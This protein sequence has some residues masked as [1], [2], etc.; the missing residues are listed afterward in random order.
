VEFCRLEHSQPF[1][2]QK[3]NLEVE[4]ET[5]FES[6]FKKTLL[7]G[8]CRIAVL[9]RNFACVVCLCLPMTASGGSRSD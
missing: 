1:S 2:R 6:E 3:S 8:A 5:P 7:P 9:R 4:K